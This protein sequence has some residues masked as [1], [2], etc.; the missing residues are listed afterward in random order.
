MEWPQRFLFKHTP[1]ELFGAD[2]KS[3]A[4]L[5]I[6][7][8]LLILADLIRR[9]Q[10]LVAHYTDFGVLPRA[11]L[12]QGEEYT[13]W[14]ISVHLANGTWEFQALLFLVAGAFAA[15][16]LIGYRTRIATIGSWF[17][18]ISLNSRNPIV[19]DAGDVLLRLTLF[20]AIFLPW[21]ARWSLDHMRAGDSEMPQRTLSAA[22]FAYAAQILF[23]YWFSVLH[24]TGPEWFDGTAVYYTLHFDQM[25]TSL[26]QYLLHF[27]FLLG[28]LTYSVFWF[29]IVGPLLLFSPI[30]TGP[31]RTAG[32]LGFFLLHIGI[33]LC[34]NLGMFT[35][36]APL[37]ML[38]LLPTWFWDK[39]SGHSR[40]V[41]RLE[42]RIYYDQD[43]SFCLRAVRF[44]KA[45]LLLPDAVVVPTQ[46]DPSVEADMR[47][48]NSWVVIDR[49]GV[50]H[51]RFNALN[52]L[53]ARSPLMWPLAA[54]L[55][56][57][58]L[59][60]IG[61]RI[62]DLVANQRRR[63]ARFF[64][65]QSAGPQR[66]NLRLGL[67]LSLLVLFLVGYVFVWNLT[68]LPNP[69]IRL[70]ERSRALGELLRIDQVWNMFAPS[71]PKYNGWYVIPGRLK[72][73]VVVDLFRDGEIL[74]WEKPSSIAALFPSYRWWKYL[75]TLWGRWDKNSWVNYASYMC[76][77]WNR[78]HH[79]SE[80]LEE[81][82]I[83]LVLEATLLDN[84]KRPLQP[85]LALQHRCG[86]QK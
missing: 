33:G 68:T 74:N 19:L 48:Q 24:K 31:I 10:D 18:L 70:L 54:I 13:R 38:G 27:P 47:A 82:R 76:R 4:T 60:H 37:T 45:F 62:Y 2:L 22:T 69:P 11:A 41:K 79:Q 15:A 16:L 8:A 20:W 3:L 65:A 25:V 39:I 63:L 44:I 26:G 34:I 86:E 58:F 71:P 6:A 59:N 83:V 50:R 67:P 28:A 51:F 61:D 84:E 35:W 80:I 52:F 81:L 66:Y 43:C 1:T 85:V 40:N 29:E 42:V 56:L 36:V 32:I 12:L 14:R 73:G 30:L 77:S 75:F 5:R 64:D 17:L 53:A 49:E 21:G 72:S 23:V 9:S 7:V 57:S 78:Y 55:R 46:S